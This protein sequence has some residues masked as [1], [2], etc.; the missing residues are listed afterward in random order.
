MCSC[1]RRSAILSER[2]RCSPRPPLPRGVAIG[3][4]AT[5]GRARE[6]RREA[7]CRRPWS[8]AHA[9][10]CRGEPGARD[11]A[12]TIEHFLQ[13][14]LRDLAVADDELAVDDGVAGADGPAAQPGL[15]RI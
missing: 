1:G 3:S 12:V 4:V 5:S 11:L 15:D 6:G 9:I 13:A 8:P 2:L 7:C 14:G 10:G